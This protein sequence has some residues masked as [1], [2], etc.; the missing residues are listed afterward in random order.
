MN[1]PE[2]L[3]KTYDK[4]TDYCT[5]MFPEEWM[6]KA[7]SLFWFLMLGIFPVSLMATVYSR[8]VYSLWF[9]RDA[10]NEHSCR[11]QVRD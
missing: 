4:K 7:Y 8:V 5:Q 10:P 9:K 6:G 11:Q 1:G 3:A 2:F